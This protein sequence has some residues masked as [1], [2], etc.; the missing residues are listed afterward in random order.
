[1]SKGPP[2]GV[3]LKDRLAVEVPSVE[4]TRLSLGLH[5]PPTTSGP[6]FSLPFSFLEPQFQECSLIKALSTDRAAEAA[7]CGVTPTRPLMWRAE[8]APGETVG[9]GTP[10][11][12]EV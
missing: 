12:G 3:T 6:H 8:P 7:P 5:H 2:T 11:R 1:M 4:G 9:P 10:P